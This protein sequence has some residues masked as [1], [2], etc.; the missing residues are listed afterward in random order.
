MIT[1]SRLF[2]TTSL[3]L[4][5]AAPVAAQE[6]GTVAAAN[7]VLDGTPPGAERRA[8]S[9]GQRVV[10]N[11]R[12][13]S[14]DTGSGHLLFRDHT[15]L[16]IAPDS[17]IVLDRYVYDPER[18]AGEIAATMAKGVLRFIGGRITDR[19]EATVE[20]PVAT[21]GIRGGMALVEVCA[22]PAQDCPGGITVIHLAGQFTRVTA[23]GQTVSLSRS[24]AR[25]TVTPGGAPV[26]TG[27]ADSAE[28][29]RLITALEGSGESGA[30]APTRAALE[31]GLASVVSVGSGAR[32]AGAGAAL[33]T[34]GQSPEPL[35]LFEAGLSTGDALGSVFGTP[36]VGPLDE[37]DMAP[38]GISG[39]GIGSGSGSGSGGGYE[40][41]F[42]YE[43]SSS[44]P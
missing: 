8:L 24:S 16:S 22:T 31:S 43:Y 35:G 15:S 38:D 19:S 1:L 44:S 41:E 18:D 14:S 21:I 9:I 11:E 32:G 28:I 33:S 2:L 10:A 34:G 3:A 4:A 26:F 7:T 25:A 13:R 23:R 5:S 39:E 20:T 27:L 12:L 37:D 42:E 36:D 40:Y 30:D 29:A 6:I 17:D